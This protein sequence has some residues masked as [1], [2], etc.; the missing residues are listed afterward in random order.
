MKWAGHDAC[1]FERQSGI[2]ECADSDDVQK[3]QATAR[4]LS[5][6]VLF[7]KAE[8]PHAVRVSPAA[9]GRARR[10]HARRREGDAPLTPVPRSP[11]PPLR[12]SAFAA[13]LRPR[14]PVPRPASIQAIVSCPAMP[15]ALPGARFAAGP[16]GR[17]YPPRVG[18]RIPAVCEVLLD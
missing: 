5:K 6:A 4:H 14:M 17:G 7:P 15:A 18:A 8:Q 13:V 3:L 10:L 1:T 16:A 12:P 2:P 9:H 11:G